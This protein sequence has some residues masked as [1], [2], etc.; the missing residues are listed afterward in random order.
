MYVTGQEMDIARRLLDALHEVIWPFRLVR[1]VVEAAHRKDLKTVLRVCSDN[2]E[3]AEITYDSS[4]FWLDEYNLPIA[5]GME[6]GGQIL[7][8]SL[9]VPDNIVLGEE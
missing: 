4:Y 6:L 1:P 2:L 9:N 7:S 8:T 5:L 3:T